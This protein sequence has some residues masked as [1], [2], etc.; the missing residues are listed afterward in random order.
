MEKNM[1]KNI[2]SLFY[3]HEYECI[4]KLT[5]CKSTMLQLKSFW[6]ENQKLFSGNQPTSLNADLGR[7]QLTHLSWPL[8]T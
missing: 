7:E 1:K 8:D 5:H 2:H 6:F 4:Q 3:I